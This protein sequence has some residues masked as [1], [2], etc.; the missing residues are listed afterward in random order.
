MRG[1]Y[2]YKIT[3]S[4][5]TSTA[6]PPNLQV[7]LNINFSAIKGLS[8]D[9]GNIRFS[10]DQAGSN[11]LYA[12]LESAPQG[13]FTQ[14]SS[15]S[16]YT[17]SNIWVNLGNNIIPANGSLTIYMQILPSGTEF[18][19]VYWGANPQWTNTYGQYDNGANVFSFYDNFTGTSLNTNKWQTSVGT[20][21]S[22]SINNGLTISGSGTSSANSV[23]VNSINAVVNSGQIL[24]GYINQGDGSTS[25]ERGMIGASSSNTVAQLWDN[26][27]TTGDTI[28]G[29]SA[30]KNG[31]GNT[32]QSETVLNGAY[33]YLQS[34][35][36]NSKLNIYSVAITS[37]AVYTW[38]NYGEVT[39]TT[40]D[41]PPAPL[42]ISL[43]VYSTG[44]GASVNMFYQW[45]RVRT[46]PPNGT[47]PV[48]TSII[49]LVGSYVS[50]ST[51]VP[52]WNVLNGKPYVTV[53]SKGISNGLSSIPNDGADFGPDTHGTQ[54][55]GIQEALSYA[56]N[57]G[58]GEVRLN[59]GTYILSAILYLQYSNI[60]LIGQDRDTTIL[61]L[62]YP[63][64]ALGSGGF[65]N[66]NPIVTTDPTGT[67]Q[68]EY[69]GIE[70]VI[71]DATE[72]GNAKASI[73]ILFSSWGS[74]MTFKNIRLVGL[75][76]T[77]ATPNG[78]NITANNITIENFVAHQSD[79]VASG[80]APAILVIG[81]GSYINVRNVYMDGY[82]EFDGGQTPY[83]NYE[84][85][86]V[87]GNNLLF[88]GSGT[89]S[90]EYTTFRNVKVYNGTGRAINGYM[91]T[92]EG[93]Y[94]IDCYF[95]G[96]VTAAARHTYQCVFNGGVVGIYDFRNNRV[97]GN[98]TAL[99]NAALGTPVGIG[100]YEN[101]NGQ[102][103]AY[104]IGN[105][106]VNINA[107]N[108]NYGAAFG[109]GGFNA[110]TDT[111]NLLI[112]KDNVFLTSFN[113]LFT[114][115]VPETSLV[116]IIE[117]NS[118]PFLT[119]MQNTNET[120]ATI[121][122]LPGSIIKNNNCLIPSYPFSGSTT[123]L[124]AN[125]PASGTVYR[126]TNPYDI[127]IYLPAYATTSGTAGSV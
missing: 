123:S 105:T 61:H 2:T 71:I 28:A 25:N 59:N 88:D 56:S 77:S 24:E 80:T 81:G 18:D 126:N 74:H 89:S 116:L 23:Y 102:Y 15:V 103:V 86:I 29:W 82:I 121:T 63:F 41:V 122:A 35:S 34:I 64:T 52:E 92:Y 83:S 109:F 79:Y 97:Y 19:G 20:G 85:I 45:V 37:S 43:S 125:P 1:I 120:P 13:T 40:S 30:G 46:F 110:S 95:E 16:S 78:F 32:I 27:G 68:P 119:N 101:E 87:N 54:T 75:N 84:N 113:G 7:R 38:Y 107:N 94:F 10:S 51:P 4:N 124:S 44:N 48:L 73:S 57:N 93:C 8:V 108:I 65:Q 127:R 99:S 118:G 50:A 91:Q 14:G 72:A 104:V 49:L 3:L 90:W 21:W 42:Y 117:N 115:A 106:F 67:T 114:Y 112:I 62:K 70:N 53:S 12:W 36:S 26:G 22:V 60:R 39:S 100:A 17:S 47:D 111:N 33:T 31:V 11:L 98:S 55:Y 6:T 58:I 66:V 9:L 96:V 5:T 76:G 69:I